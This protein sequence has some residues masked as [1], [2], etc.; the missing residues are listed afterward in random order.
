M[1]GGSARPHGGKEANGGRTM[2]VHI[3]LFTYDDL[4]RMPNDGKR[5]E[6]CDGE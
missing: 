1:A 2:A 3:P 4:A 6:L 5:Y